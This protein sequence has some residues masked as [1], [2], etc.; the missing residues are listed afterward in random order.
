M[1]CKSLLYRWELSW[2][3]CDFD[4]ILCHA[5]IRSSE[6]QN[7][8]YLLTKIK[9]P[10]IDEVPGIQVNMLLLVLIFLL[11]LILHLHCV[12]LLWCSIPWCWFFSHVDFSLMLIFLSCWFFH[13]LIFSHVDFSHMLIFLS[14]WFFY[15]VDFSIMLILVCYFLVCYFLVCYWLCSPRKLIY[16]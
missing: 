5:A 15:H 11:L 1:Y 3:I 14:C 16:V 6:V 7:A 9:S 13:M 2:I 4:S 10:I 8:R 12:F